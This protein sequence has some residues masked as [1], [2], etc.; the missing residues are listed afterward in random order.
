MTALDLDPDAYDRL[1]ALGES[2]ALAGVPNVWDDEH[3]RGVLDTRATTAR[4]E[5]A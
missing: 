5:D 4:E 2:H 1:E 3:W